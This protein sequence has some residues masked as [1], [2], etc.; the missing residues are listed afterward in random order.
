MD[1]HNKSNNDCNYQTRNTLILCHNIDIQSSNPPV[2]ALL[3]KYTPGVCVHVSLCGIHLRFQI[4]SFSGIPLIFTTSKSSRI[5]A[6]THSGDYIWERHPHLAPHVLLQ[7][8]FLGMPRCWI[9]SPFLPRAAFRFIFQTV[10]FLLEHLISVCFSY[11]SS[12]FNW[13]FPLIVFAL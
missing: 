12:F 13:V 5:F 6:G 8:G 10:C 7:S 4:V 9:S 3:I 1:D 11:F 2:W